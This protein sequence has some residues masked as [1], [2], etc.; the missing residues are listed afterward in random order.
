MSNI[1]KQKAS[2]Y[3][4]FRSRSLLDFIGSNDGSADT[5][6]FMRDGLDFD[7]VNDSVSIGNTGLTVKTVAIMLSPKTTSEDI[8]DL[9]GGTHT[10]EVGA[11]TVTA[12]G[13]S[14]PTIYV[15]GAETSTLADN[16][17]QTIIITTATGFSASNFDLGTETTF[18][19]GVISAC[20]F[21]ADELTATEADE[22]HSE[23]MNVKW[24]TKALTQVTKKIDFKPDHP[25][26][27][28]YDGT[29][30]GATAIDLSDNGRDGA[31][32]T[33]IN[34]KTW[35][36]NSFGCTTAS[37]G[38]ERI[39]MG[40]DFISTGDIAVY[41]TF[42]ANSYGSFGR[43]IDNNKYKLYIIAGGQRLVL[44]SDGST[45]ALPNTGSIVT[46]RW[47]SLVVNRPSGGDNCEIYINGIDETSVADSGT[48]AAGTTNVFVFNNTNS[49][50]GFDGLVADI[51]MSSTLATAA[52]VDKYCRAS[53]SV[54]QFKTDWG[55]Y[56]S[57]DNNSTADSQLENSPFKVSTGTWGVATDTING[58]DIKVLNCA[59]AGILYLR[60]PDFIEAT[61][62]AFGSWEFWIKKDLDA[63]V[64]DVML[65]AD[66]IGG[67]AAAGQDGYGVR[68]DDDETVALFESVAGTPTDKFSSGAKALQTW[69]KVKVT[70]STDGLFEL[71]VDDTSIGTVTDRTATTS[72][73]LAF[74]FGTGDKIA[75][76]DVNGNYAFTKYLGEI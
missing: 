57:I 73:Y 41:C 13:F 60:I 50:R 72:T 52:D 24:P 75:Y 53:A 27:F 23:L 4:D 42:K 40:A 25:Y 46:N 51:R 43:I 47:Y 2:F 3:M 71:F 20:V 48:P 26:M 54:V 12:T 31:V 10:V 21:F 19:N 38:T 70:R 33:I 11:G 29:I 37:G 64:M 34:K 18:F 15:A 65:V 7:G 17:N 44:N 8:A 59:S 5:P 32:E 61:D 16:K 66:T 63:N 14:S 39:D 22:V 35:F 55:V 45:S 74:A 62:S 56:E 36:G 30:V 9:D 68:F 28:H 58:K 76:S 49:N 1:I 67:G 6:Y 69:V